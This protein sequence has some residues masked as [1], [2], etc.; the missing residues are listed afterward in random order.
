MG[1]NCRPHAL[2]PVRDD[3]APR[4]VL[5]VRVGD[6]VRVEDRECTS[7]AQAHPRW[8]YLRASQTEGAGHI[9]PDFHTRPLVSPPIGSEVT[10]VPNPMIHYRVIIEHVRGLPRTHVDL[11]PNGKSLSPRQKHRS[12]Q[13]PMYPPARVVPQPVPDVRYLGIASIIGTRPSSGL[14]FPIDSYSSGL[15]INISIMAFP[16]RLTF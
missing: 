1:L 13:R 8:C 12:N 15:V 11:V 6:E 16:F 14:P 2:H 7:R 10:V 5:L 9:Q 3:A 4:E